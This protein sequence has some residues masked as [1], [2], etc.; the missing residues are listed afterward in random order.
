MSYGLHNF[1]CKLSPLWSLFTE[2]ATSGNPL[3]STPS[4]AW[5]SRMGQNMGQKCGLAVGQ[6]NW[7]LSPLNLDL[8]HIQDHFGFTFPRVALTRFSGF[9]SLPVF[10]P[11]AESRIFLPLP[12]IS[13]P[14]STMGQKHGSG[15]FLSPGAENRSLPRVSW[16]YH[17]FQKLQVFSFKRNCHRTASTDT[18][19]RQL[20]IRNKQIKSL[21]NWI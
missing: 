12:V 14:G 10:E 7:Q 11:P 18:T 8:R 6:P 16:L 3:K 13:C 15:C 9:F 19:R 17:S 20:T 2:F 1:L 5:W 21:R 4:T